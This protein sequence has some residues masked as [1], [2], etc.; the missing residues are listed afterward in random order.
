MVGILGT[1][2]VEVKKDQESKIITITQRGSL[3]SNVIPSVIV[4]CEDA[5]AE[6]TLGLV[7]A[8]T[9]GSYKIV[10]AG[11]W[12]NM[13][14]LLYGM[15]FY[16]KHLQQTGDTRFLEVLC[17][18]DGDISPPWFH[19]VIEETHR[20]SHAPSHVKETLSLIKQNLI[21]FKLSDHP[22]NTKGIPEYNH[23]KW[24][25]EITEH[26]ISKHFESRIAELNSFLEKS[27]RDQEGGI[28]VEIFLIKRE[29][30]ETL[31]IIE[32]SRRMKFKAVDNLVDFHA[33]YKRLSAVLRRG[34]TFTHYPQN[35]MV[36]A[37]LSIIRKFNS[38]RWHS[39]IAPIKGSME[40]AFINQVN[41]FR[42]D[43]FNNMEIG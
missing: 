34:D 2:S 38:A 7:A 29:I 20:G 22:K 8:E 10:T 27:T 1:T 42:K 4:V 6:R 18:T 39:Y 26:H 28:S 37:V 31:R 14:T 36:Y 9:K 21:S 16:R 35:D 24:L 25:D 11:A 5:V 43:R 13:A 32:A 33:Y 23:K 3:I 41:V 17:V 19:K 40:E 30:S 12:G 15:Y